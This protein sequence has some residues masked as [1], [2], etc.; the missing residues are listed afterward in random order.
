MWWNLSPNPS[1]RKAGARG[2]SV[3]QDL[4]P[5]ARFAGVCGTLF[6]L[7]G[8]PYRIA[9]LGNWPMDPEL[10]DAERF[11]PNSLIPVL[12]AHV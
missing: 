9:W 5:Q 7:G 1:P 8:F 3:P 6:R 12:M 10:G 2:K 11:L 4:A